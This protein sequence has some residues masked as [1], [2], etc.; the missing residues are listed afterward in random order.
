MSREDTVDM[1]RAQSI[2]RGTYAQP[3]DILALSKKLKK[4][5]RFGLA[6]KILNRA[7][8]DSE[9]E[10]DKKLK[11]EVAQ[12]QA[13]CTYKDPD[14]PISDRLERAL[15]ILNKADNLLTT[16]NQETLGQ[17]GAVFKRKWE[18]EGH[19]HYLE[20]SLA[21]YYRGYE[22]GP[23]N[24]Y[25]YTGIN[26]AFVMDQLADLE[27]KEAVEAGASS[28]TARK[29]REQ[30]TRIRKDLVS[31]LPGL[32]DQNNWLE[33]TYWF[34][35]TIAEANFGLDLYEDARPWL[36]QAAALSGI[37]PWELETT[38]RQ[39][40]NLVRLHS[41]EKLEKED[42]E[43]NPAWDVLKEFLGNKAEGVRTVFLGK[44][45]LAL[46]G[47]GFRASLFHI[48]VLAKLAEL[49]MLRYVEVL[50][51]VSGG[52]IIGA[53]YYLEVRHLLQTKADHEITREHYIDIIMRICDRFIK[54]VQRNIRTRVAA[55]FLTN[56]KMIFFPDYSRTKRVGELY[57]EEIYSVIEDQ[58]GHKHR[59]LNELFIHPNGEDKNF[60]PK[61][62]NWRRSA[63]V[64]ILILNAATLNT[65]HNWQF[66]ASW[67]GEPPSAINTAIDGNY[68]LR[69]MYYHE[70]PSS[71]QQIRL[72]H[73]V[74]AS[75]CV[76]GLFEPIVL[77]KLYKRK[78]KGQDKEITVRLVDG[79]VHDN[80]GIMG[81]LEQDCDAILVSDASGQMD[82]QD[83]PS[84]GVIGV[85]LRSNSILMARVRDAE[86][87]EIDARLRSSLLRNLMFI[88]LKKDLDVNPVDWTGCQEPHDAS[89]EA[90]PAYR[91][92]VLTGYG[93]LKEVQERLAAIRTDLDS[94]ADQEAYALM[95][96]G[97]RMVESDCDRQFSNFPRYT[98]QRS[99]WPFLRLEDAMTNS[100]KSEG[101]SNFLDASNKRAFKIWYLSWPLKICAV[102]LGLSALAGFFW[103][104][105]KWPSL[106]LLTLGAIGFALAV[107]LVSTIIG[108]TIVGI[109]RFRETL[110][111]IGIGI[112][113]ALLGWV[114]A[115]I[116]LHVFDRLYL[117]KGRL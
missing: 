5:N 25:G 53:H 23:A 46:S 111:K 7:L 14:L 37:P 48:G 94:F 79:G 45:G 86:Y 75:A 52:S 96:S 15:K 39:L 101:L 22:V 47:G 19:K 8:Q 11:L 115:R 117:R 80:Q 18:A 91:R 4:K 42:I 38:A 27:E 29:R 58:E 81:L 56:L 26:A 71:H 28:D 77:P 51:C 89:D 43:K 90:R 61:H 59:W 3:A 13:L 78:D 73:A 68:R 17:A 70:A 49:D 57:E 97:Y 50:S 35:V 102:L 98:G 1:E 16:K 103:A 110:S 55:E 54:G 40:A 6:R 60:Q 65:G 30:A 100:V 12:Q 67:M 104:C 108:K 10:Q 74:A 2:L 92:G 36:Q 93:I 9:I 95:T 20:R 113:M 21:Y 84:R 31:V 87:R 64:P 106:T 69:R 112:A 109:V 62:E 107:L 114:F 44:F 33:K 63:K 41:K 82:T 24:D 34:L 32:I 76:P 99:D 105:W 83:N 88:H 72:G 85:P 116:H 66:T